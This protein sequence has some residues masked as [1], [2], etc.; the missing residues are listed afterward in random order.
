[1]WDLTTKPSAESLTTGF[2]FKLNGEVT[3]DI[4]VMPKLKIHKSD[5]SFFWVSFS[6]YL[7]TV[8]EQG[9]WHEITDT[10]MIVVSEIFRKL[11]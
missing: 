10:Q 4:S 1:M 3:T 5:G 6:T 9:D 2:Y 7:I 8:E 11:E